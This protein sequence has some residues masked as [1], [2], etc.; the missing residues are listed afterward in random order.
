MAKK[1]LNATAEESVETIEPT[2]EVQFTVKA[3]LGEVMMTLSAKTRT[4]IG[5]ETY[6]CTRAEW[7]ALQ[8]SGCFDLVE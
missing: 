8:Q 7:F 5:G 1:H 4:F 6:G 2:P 3:E